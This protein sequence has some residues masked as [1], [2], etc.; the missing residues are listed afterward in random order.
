MMKDMQYPINHQLTTK[1]ASMFLT[2]TH[3][4]TDRWAAPN[5]LTPCSLEVVGYMKRILIL[6]SSGSGKSTL[7][8]RLGA[9][10]ELPV[11]HLDRHYWQPGWVPTPEMEWVETVNQIIQ[12][13]QWIIDGNYRSTLDIRLQAADTIVFLDLPPWLCALRATKRRIQYANTPRP[14]MAKGCRERLFDPQFPEFIRHIWTYPNR[15]RPDV[16]KRLANYS[17]DKEIIWL[18]T[19]DDV[20]QF[21]SEPLNPK[22]CQQHSWNGRQNGTYLNHTT[23]TSQI[24][25]KSS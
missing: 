9:T 11:I 19:T 24:S 15:A 7:A 25:K 16:K 4:L 13:P 22:F 12:R 10:L 8:R 1:P 2:S 6:G 23:S 5:P 17:S 18:K 14:D 21:L 20:S 3:Y